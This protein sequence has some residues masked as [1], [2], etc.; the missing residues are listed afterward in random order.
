MQVSDTMYCVY[1]PITASNPLGYCHVRKNTD[2]SHFLCTGKDCR[3]FAGKGKQLKS[4]SMNTA[5]K[6]LRMRKYLKIL[7]GI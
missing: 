7:W 1:G 5:E 2:S 4:K 6:R 3:G